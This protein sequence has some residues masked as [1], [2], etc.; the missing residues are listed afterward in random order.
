MR[1]IFIT[2]NQTAIHFQ[3]KSR[4]SSGVKNS[5][6]ISLPTF[7][8]LYYRNISPKINLYLMK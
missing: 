5:D 1:V 3:E 6:S 8:K 4:Y 7:E 2:S